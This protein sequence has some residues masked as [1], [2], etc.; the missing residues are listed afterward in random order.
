MTDLTKQRK[1][2]TELL[3]QNVAQGTIKPRSAM[4]L[5][6]RINTSRLAMQT[7]I[8]RSLQNSL[9]LGHK[10]TLTSIS[11]KAKSHRQQENFMKKTEHIKRKDDL[12]VFTISVWMKGTPVDKRRNTVIRK[13]PDV[14]KR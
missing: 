13:F 5:T 10:T 1:M 6:N 7:N 11:Q 14:K 3:L 12:S 8:I 9:Y 2:A 4:A